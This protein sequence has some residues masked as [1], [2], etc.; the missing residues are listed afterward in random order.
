MSYKLRVMSYAIMVVVLFFL[1]EEL[2]ESTYAQ[3]LFHI[4]GRLAE[5]GAMTVFPHMLID[6]EQDTQSTGRDIVQFSAIDHDV[7]VVTFEERCQVAFSLGTSRRV[8]VAN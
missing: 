1:F 4:V 6:I 8:E 5:E 3:H 7:A 2:E